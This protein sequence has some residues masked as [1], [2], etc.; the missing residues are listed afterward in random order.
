M[1]SSAIITLA[2][3]VSLVGAQKYTNTSSKYRLVANH[4]HPTFFDDFTLWNAG[5]PT[6]GTVNYTNFATA[7]EQDLLGW[8]WY[9][10]KNFSHAYLGVDYKTVLTAP[11]NR[12]SVRMLGKYTYEVGLLT[13]IDVHHIPT[14]KAL[15]PA[16]WYLANNTKSAEL[17][18]PHQG[19]QDIMEW[20]NENDYNSMTL[21]TYSGC[22]TSNESL[23]Y[24]GN[25]QS[26][27]CSAGNGSEGC[28]IHAPSSYMFNGKQLATAGPDFNKQGGAVYIH[29]WTT[30]GV[31]VWLFP[32]DQLPLDL[33]RGAPNP[34]SW[35]QKPLA[36]WSGKHCDFGTQFVSQQLIINIDF[37]GQWAGKVYNPQLGEQQGW[38]QCNALVRNNPEAFKDAYFDFASIKIYSSNPQPPVLAPPPPPPPNTTTTRRR[39][40]S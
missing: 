25:L 3:A 21:H 34:S 18:W 7:K 27:N 24:L 13:V 39:R 29:E 4:Q 6:D 12:N 38:D 32:R 37:C 5:D 33:Q 17:L 26:T 14:G 11:I 28:S 20:V 40:R 10:D 23:S 2:L 1:Y 15:W 36:R 35:S 9:E 16:I 30:E 31:S 22:F 19:E 8:I